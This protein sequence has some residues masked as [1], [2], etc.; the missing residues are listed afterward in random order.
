MFCLICQEE[1][2]IINDKDSIVTL[3]C[4]CKNIYHIEC[5]EKWYSYK[6]KCPLCF[7]KKS[8]I[9]YLGSANKFK[10]KIIETLLKYIMKYNNKAIRE[11]IEVETSTLSKNKEKILKRVITL[12]SI[13]YS[14]YLTLE[15]YLNYDFSRSIGIEKEYGNDIIKMMKIIKFINNK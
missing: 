8:K 7:N 5:L 12:E 2:D 1:I 10:E 3:N 11:I 4:K 15:N 14:V 13:K 6:K 9:I